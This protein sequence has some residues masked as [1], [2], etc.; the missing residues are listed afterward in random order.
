MKTGMRSFLRLWPSGVLIAAAVV[1]L[2]SVSSN[3]GL[4]GRGAGDD[5]SDEGLLK[6]TDDAALILAILADD[7]EIANAPVMVEQSIEGLH[8]RER[9]S[10]SA[11]DVRSTPHL[12]GAG[13][14]PEK[15][16]ARKSRAK[17]S[18]HKT[19]KKGRS[20][21][22]QQPTPSVPPDSNSP[23]LLI[24]TPLASAVVTLASQTAQYTPE[25]TIPQISPSAI[26]TVAATRVAVTPIAAPGGLL[27]PIGSTPASVDVSPLPAGSLIS[28]TPSYRSVASPA[29]FGGAIPAP[30]GRSGSASVDVA[31]GTLRVQASDSPSTIRI[32]V[33]TQGVGIVQASFIRVSSDIDGTLGTFPRMSVARIEF[34]GGIS[35]D[36][37]SAVGMTIP[38]VAL[39]H[40]GHDSLTGGAARNSIDGGDGDDIIQAAG[41]SSFY[42]QFG[43]D[44]ITGGDGADYIDGGDGNDVINAGGGDDEVDGGAGNDTIDGGAGVDVLRGFVGMDD[45]RG[46]THND[47]LEGGPGLDRLQGDQGDDTLRGGDERDVIHGNSGSDTI[48]GGNG[49]DLILGGAEND[50]IFGGAGLDTIDGETGDDRIEGGSEDDT[51]QGGVGRDIVEGGDGADTLRGGPDADVV[52]GQNGNDTIFGEDGDDRLFGNAGFD[53]LDGG[54]GRDVVNGGAG[55]D[56]LAGGDDDDWLVAIDDENFDTVRGGTGRDNFWRD[57]GVANS[58]VLVDMSPGDADHGVRQ[59]ANPGADRTLNGDEIPGPAAPADLAIASFASNPLFSAVGPSGTDISQGD[60]SDCKVV[61]G[62]SALAR[63]NRAGTNWAIRRAM[64]DFGDGTYGLHL[65]PNF[66]RVDARFPL[67]RSNSSIPHYANLGPEGSIWVSVA[68]KGIV[69]AAS[70]VA[71]SPQYED[72]GSVGADTVFALFGSAQVGTPLISSYTSFDALRQDITQRFVGANPQYLSI[73]LNNDTLGSLGRRFVTGHAY[74][75]WDLTYGADGGLENIIIRNPWGT[76]HGGAQRLYSDEDPNDGFIALPVA[77]LF[78]SQTGRLNWG[79]RV[80]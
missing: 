20:K 33:V 3:T 22:R 12:A 23:T 36:T 48:E 66:Y 56:T 46:G 37:F 17:K 75:V 6:Q 25:V 4:L 78:N 40:D 21:R 16:K 74:T 76:D 73:S 38:V 5:I 55:T 11:I 42:G 79:I 35:D 62:L 51:I 61:S 31:T 18:R 15:A 45:L 72:L 80:P 29:P 39:G 30:A 10:R 47:V 49:D 32:D 50:A 54:G 28:G 57:I 44:R 65:G 24:S 13:P 68:E 7:D 52:R 63:T 58:D 1:G 53:T 69:L 60:V 41:P 71:G 43:D 9:G 59:F 14:T 26:A 34:N 77:A 8:G 70:R 67:S 27:T 19:R 64:V 2:I